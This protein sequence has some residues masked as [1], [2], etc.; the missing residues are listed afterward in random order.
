MSTLIKLVFLPLKL[1][2]VALK[3]LLLP[4]KMLRRPRRMIRRMGKGKL[5]AMAATGAAGY[6][7]GRQAGLREGQDIN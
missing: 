1:V 7:L 4:F 6:H 5:L 3:M 2:G